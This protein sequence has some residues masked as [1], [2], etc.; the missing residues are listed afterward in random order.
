MLLVRIHHEHGQQLG[1]F[2]RAR[3]LIESVSITWHFGEVL[4]GAINND[5]SIIDRCSDGSFEN[6][7]VD[8]SRFGMDVARRRNAGTIFDEHTLDTFTRHIWKSVIEDERD[9]WT[10]VFGYR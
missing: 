6:R 3:I 10:F 9:L 5:R 2:G 7:C 1:R 4:P 8:E